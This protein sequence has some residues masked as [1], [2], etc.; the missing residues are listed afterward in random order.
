M[1]EAVMGVREESLMSNLHHC[2]LPVQ[3]SLY[4][5][6]SGL[7]EGVVGCDGGH[8]AE[9]HRTDPGKKAAVADGLGSKDVIVT[10]CAVTGHDAAEDCAEENQGLTQAERQDGR[11]VEDEATLLSP[12]VDQLGPARCVDEPPHK[13]GG[14]ERN[15]QNDGCHEHVGHD[16]VE[17][18]VEVAVDCVGDGDQQENDSGD[19]QAG[20]A[21]QLEHKHANGNVE[22]SSN[23]DAEDPEEGH[24]NSL[25]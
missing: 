3:T 11:D 10:D 17:A 5:D 4:I 6:P 9:K 1:G 18:C 20:P 23:D 16:V 24:G 14:D 12:A 8:T 21:E 15:D 22:Y 7:L 19:N 25:H 2:Y 13:P